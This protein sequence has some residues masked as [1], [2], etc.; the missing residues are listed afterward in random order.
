MK[1]IYEKIINEKYIGKQINPIKQEDIFNLAYK[2]INKY[3]FKKNNNRMALLIVDMQRDFID[4]KKGALPVKGAVKDT[5]RVIEFIYSNLEH[6]SR[7]YTTMDTH[8][9]NSIFHPYMWKK[10]NGEEV[11]PF[12][13]ITL[14]KIYEHKI[15]PMYKKEQ[16]EY[17]K[18]L[19]ESKSKNLVIWPYHC[20]HG[21]DG[22]LIEK[23]LNNMLLFYERIRETNIHKVIKGTERFSEMYGAVRPEIVTQETRFFDMAWVYDLKNYK[24]IYICGEAKDFGLYNTLQQICDVYSSNKNITKRINVM[25]NCSSCISNNITEVNK[26]YQK[27]QKDYEI[28]IIEI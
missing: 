20:I 4:P 11:E 25:I 9:Y 1:D 18:K 22:W 3:D 16:I 8:Y 12:T 10:E 23:Q 26:N 21:T 19:K 17:V 24:K 27:L 14:E 13:E 7:I 15:I 5:K 6:I 2:Y 28:N